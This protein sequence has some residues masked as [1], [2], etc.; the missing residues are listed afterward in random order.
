MESLCV[1]SFLDINARHLVLCCTVCCVLCAVCCVLSLLPSPSRDLLLE[2]D[3][4][5]VVAFRLTRDASLADC[6]P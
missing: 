4:R 6:R 1:S 5:Q 2:R 3:L